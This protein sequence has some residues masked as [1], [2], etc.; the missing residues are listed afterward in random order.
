MRLFSNIYYTIAFVGAS[1]TLLLQVILS[2]TIDP[3]LAA[4]VTPFYPIWVIVLVVGWRKM[5]PRK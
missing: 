4:A 3:Y 5:H 1:V 2:L